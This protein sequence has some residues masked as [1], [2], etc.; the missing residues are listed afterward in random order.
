MASLPKGS[1]TVF[2]VT[3]ASLKATSNTWI[4]VVSFRV[5]T[6]VIIAAAVM[7]VIVMAMSFE[8]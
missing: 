5:A 6:T 1:I 4:I 3:I 7:I 2:F 8:L